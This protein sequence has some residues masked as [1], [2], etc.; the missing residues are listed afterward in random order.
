MEG[1]PPQAQMVNLQGPRRRLHPWRPPP[2]IDGL[3]HLPASAVPAQL[4]P[5]FHKHF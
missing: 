1:V 4:L 2:K 5:H 3:K